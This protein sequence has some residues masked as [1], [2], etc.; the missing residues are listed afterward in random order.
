MS[1]LSIA[2]SETRFKVMTLTFDLTPQPLRTYTIWLRLTRTVE[3]MDN[4]LVGQRILYK[5]CGTEMTGRLLD[6]I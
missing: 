1:E 4:F 6:S 5:M 3:Q 2:Q